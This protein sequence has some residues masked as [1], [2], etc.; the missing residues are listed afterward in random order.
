MPSPGFSSQQIKWANL[1]SLSRE[2]L[3]LT[4]I[5]TRRRCKNGLRALNRSWPN[6]LGSKCRA[7]CRG[8]VTSTIAKKNLAYSSCASAF[9]IVWCRKRSWGNRPW[10]SRNC[11]ISSI[12][13]KRCCLQ[14]KNCGSS[15]TIPAN[16]LSIL[17][18][19]IIQLVGGSMVERRWSSRSM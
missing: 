7:W 9:R 15:R 2:A 11:R 16:K 6:T 1:D 14:T 12:A 4:I 13:N 18:Y 17:G 10:M 8:A 3:T 5:W 19:A